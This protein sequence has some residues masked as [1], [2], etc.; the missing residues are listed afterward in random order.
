MNLLIVVDSEGQACITRS[1]VP[2]RRSFLQKIKSVLRISSEPSVTYS[3]A[4]GR[5][6]IRRISLEVASVVRAAFDSGVRNILVHDGG[7]IRGVTEAG[8]TLDYDLIPRG[9]LFSVGQ[10]SLEISARQMQ[11]DAAI[12]LGKHAMAGNPSGVMA[13]TYS[14]TNVKKMIL[15]GK[16]V[17]EI[18]IESLQL[19]SLGIPVIM[20]AGDQAACDEASAFLGK[21]EVAPL[22]KGISAHA[23]ISIH[24]EDALDL[25]YQK[26]ATAISKH[27]LFKPLSWSDSYDLV[28]K[29]YTKKG[30][31]A[32]A[33][34]RGARYLPPLAYRIQTE[35]PWQLG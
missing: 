24:P 16:E 21:V 3:S 4:Q 9:V 35:N 25:L 19:S 33:Q 26:T 31:R 15:N 12:L 23:A 18:G 29:C 27:S 34:R 14:S 8:L 13:H 1:S 11:F 22:K 17:G 20:V 10:V 32:R 5:D 28:V 6:N 30:A 2:M 7:F